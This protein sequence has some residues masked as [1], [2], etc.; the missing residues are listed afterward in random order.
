MLIATPATAMIQ[1][2]KCLVPM[3]QVSAYL[4]KDDPNLTT[5]K[6]YSEMN[7]RYRLI[8]DFISQSSISVE[9][10]AQPFESGQMVSDA[11]IDAMASQLTSS[12]STDS[13]KAWA[14]YN[15]IINNIYY[16]YDYYEG[17]KA[18]VYRSATD[19]FKYKYTV[20]E[21]YANLYTAMCRSVGVPCRMVIG[22]SVS[23]KIANPQELYD[24]Y[25]SNEITHAWNEIYLDGKW[26]V[27]DATWDSGNKYVNGEFKKYTSTNKYYQMDFDEFAKR[28]M[29]MSYEGT[30]TDGVFDYTITKNQITAKNYKGADTNVVV[31]EGVNVVETLSSNNTNIT[32]VVLPNSLTAIGTSSLKKC[33]KLKELHI[34]QTVTT[35]GGYAFSDCASLQ[36]ITL[37]SNLQSL[38]N[39]V[40]SGCALL[41]SIVIPDKITEIPSAA[42]YGCTALSSV[43]LSE[44]IIKIGNS[45]F[46][47]CTTLSDI[48]I[49]SKVENIGNSAFKNCV[50]IKSVTIPDSTT[51]LS[52]SAFYGCTGLEDVSIG[53]AI[54]KILKNCFN[55]CTALKN[56]HL[57]SGVTEIGYN[58]FDGCSALVT[59]SGGENIKTL[60][61]YAFANCTLLENCDFFNNITWLGPCAFRNCASITSITIPFTYDDISQS[62]FSGCKSLEKV[63]IIGDVKYI[64]N[65]AFSGCSSLEE[66]NLPSGLETI[67]KAAFQ[68]CYKL[69]NIGGDI[70]SSV[71]S[72]GEYAFYD[73]P[74]CENITIPDGITEI[75]KSA[76]YQSVRVKSITIPTS[77]TAIREF[78]FCR[79]NSLNDIY[80]LGTEE[81]WNQITIEN[82]NARFLNANIHFLGESH[83]H[84]YNSSVTIE[85]SCTSVGEKTYTCECGD[86]YTDEIP[87]LAH[88]ES[89]WITD[90]KATCTKVGT[91][92]T[93]CTVC[94]TQIQTGTIEKLA[95][96]EV[97]IPAV[98]A[99]CTSTG[100]TEGKKC[101][102]C[103]E[104]I[105]AQT[106]I[107]KLAHTES[108]W[109]TDSNPTCTKVGTKH[110]ECTVCHTEIKTGTIE[111]LPHSEVTIPTVKAT[112]TSTGLTEGKKC[113]ACGEVTVKQSTI[114]KIAHSDAN[115]D[116]KCDMCMSIIDP[117]KNCSCNCHKSGFSGLI[118]KILCFFYKIF[119]TN[120]VCGCGAAHY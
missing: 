25:F 14:L 22:L 35:I 114:E 72:I 3:L 27:V 120:R 110:T 111:K 90:T 104:I 46:S 89:E 47:G 62:S 30:F 70:P 91:K 43:K 106:E 15:W 66:I 38:G 78:A 50:A 11:D 105:T 40:F 4:S 63:T 28:H 74:L 101:S 77:V 32:T 85:P 93:E 97:A 36:N 69:E 26:Y 81:Q 53:S 83:T 73:C 108:E 29:G 76:F 5:E 44:S 98:K 12:C 94:H 60:R 16:D 107:P 119:G 109:K 7:E 84:S 117:T 20:C 52:A 80:Y 67:G 17:R 21:G 100:L 23:A 41:E 2:E 113:S 42:F 68:Q 61:D 115:G 31:P 88:T 19:V 118:W 59:V 6:V 39:R 87:K 37:P 58:S 103:G 55:G 9:S 8:F 95:H 65:Y 54:T 92:H 48:N 33:T 86:S 116:N 24:K 10:Q 13:E 51:T 112:C 82:N 57:G 102:A 64:D 71:R 18:T 75:P 45:A 96:S 34:P 79:V 56:L 1:G 49:P 99:T